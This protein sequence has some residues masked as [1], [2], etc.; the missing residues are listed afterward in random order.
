M[1]RRLVRP[2][3]LF[4]IL[5]PL[6]LL[7]PLLFTGKAMFWGTPATQF[8][9]WWSFASEVLQSR[10]LP[11]W[12]P[13]LGM[14]APLIA[15]YQSGI[16]YPPNWMYFILEWLG[17][18]PLMAWGLALVATAHLAWAGI[19]M[20]L[21]VKRLGVGELGQTIAGISY[22]LSGYLVSRSGFLSINSA[23]AWLPWVILLL[24]VLIDSVK[25]DSEGEHCGESTL[26]K[27]RPLLGN[28]KLRPFLWLSLVLGLLLLTGHAQIAWYTIILAFGWALVI[29][30]KKLNRN[31]SWK[32][33]VLL[34]FAAL[35]GVFLAAVQLLPTVEYLNESQRSSSV[36]YESA[37][38]YSLWPWQ[39]MTL[40]APDLFGNPVDGDYWGYANYWEE[41]VYIG[42]AP[43]LLAVIAIATRFRERE[44]DRNLWSYLVPALLVIILLSFLLAL[45]WY[46]PVFPWL[47]SHIP[48]FDMFQG[49]ARISL[50]AVFSLSIL[51]GIGTELW[52][53]PSGKA[54][55]W[56]RLG[57]MAA[58]AVVVSALAANVL[59]RLAGLNFEQ[60]FIR[61]LL[62]AGVWGAGFGIL[63]LT[64][65]GTQ[66]MGT[67]V[68]SRGRWYWAAC[69]WVA[70]DLLF[71]SWGIIP[72]IDRNFYVGEDPST[73]QVR[74]MVGD[75]RLYLTSESERELKFK[76]FFRF[77]TFSPPDGE[78]NWDELRTSLLPNLT[79]L[80][81]IPTANNFDPLLPERYAKWISSLSELSGENRDKLIS[82]MGVTVL[83]ILTEKGEVRFISHK[84]IPRINWVPCGISASS[85]DTAFNLVFGGEVNFEE[86]AVVEGTEEVDEDCTKD[87][88]VE[89]R[90]RTDEPHRLEVEIYASNPGYLVVSDV[91]YPGWR[92]YRDGQPVELA[93]ANYLFRGIFI[94]AGEHV[95]EMQYQPISFLVGGVVSAAAWLAWLILLVLSYAVGRK[96]LEL[97]SS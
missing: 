70:A 71:A 31:S 26:P 90:T 73:S 17:G 63:T 15:N 84:S 95:I 64:A 59:T 10:H 92:A 48:T 42:L 3:F 60:S 14:G 50:L 53:K 44:M 72:G 27:G 37:M 9:P 32:A 12:N 21:L 61:S 54:L 20:V 55:Y 67:P 4:V 34:I 91:W 85:G 62:M 6:I 68:D 81:R 49:P 25:S 23:C 33:W 46:T 77:D 41:A 28:K 75:G 47:Y 45:G 87:S 74:S 80:A 52:H 11:L 36:D 39:L 97:H 35:F 24:T 22:G 29:T 43:L 94:P 7:S 89:L 13:Y 58:A 76:R 18:T 56:A 93:R 69:S 1:L 88:Q 8:I 16:F 83:E 66:V 38:S 78:S 86:T 51:A 5:T 79:L 65:P 96:S 82:L 2:P 30:W 57:V 40:F 19:G